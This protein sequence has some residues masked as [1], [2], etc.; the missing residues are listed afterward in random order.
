VLRGV[1]LE[2]ALRERGA[3]EATLLRHEAALATLAQHCQAIATHRLSS[4]RARVDLDAGV[5]EV[6]HRGRLAGPNAMLS[7]RMDEGARSFAGQR[8]VVAW[9]RLRGHDFVAVLPVGTS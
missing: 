3:D 5:V 6:Q 9:M 4:Y 2:R 7:R 1:F 8:A